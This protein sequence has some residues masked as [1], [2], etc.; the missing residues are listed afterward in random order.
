[1]QLTI[2]CDKCG[3]EG[4]CHRG[5]YGHISYPFER[6]TVVSWWENKDYY[7]CKTCEKQLDVI[8]KN[9]MGK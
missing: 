9:F 3:A 4:K 5:Q 1:M 6:I 8:L 7:L 2:K